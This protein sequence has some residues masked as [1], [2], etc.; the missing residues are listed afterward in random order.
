MKCVD[1]DSGRIVGMALWDIYLTPSAWEK[2][3]ISWLQ[4]QEKERAEQLISPLWEARERLWHRERYIY[5]HVVAVHPE[6]QRQGIGQTLVDYGISV[7]KQTH[8]PIYIESSRDG[9]RLYEK[10]GCRKLE[11]CSVKEVADRKS[12]A[13]GNSLEASE[14]DL[15]IW[16]EGTAEALPKAVQ[17]LLK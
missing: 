15:F 11:K 14:V 10:L 6:Y 1:L 16:T 7:A 4:G 17:I 12:D 5:C 2:G 3:E 9:R 13:I 8:L